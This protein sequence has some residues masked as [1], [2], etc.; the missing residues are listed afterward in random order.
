MFTRIAQRA[1]TF[2]PHF[3]P[4]RTP[5][6]IQPRFLFS[7]GPANGTASG[8]DTPQLVKFTIVDEQDKEYQV[9]A[10]VGQNLMRAGLDAKV[11]FPVACGGNAECC[12]CHVYLNLH[13]MQD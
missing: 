10:E 2:L 3:N 7:S 11:P 9:E 6:P 1:N 12:T 5:I 8:S 13:I 4:R